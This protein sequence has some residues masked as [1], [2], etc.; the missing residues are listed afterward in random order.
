MSHVGQRIIDDLEN[1]RIKIMYGIDQRADK[2]TY[3]MDIYSP[4][5]ELPVVDAIVVT[6]Y[7]FDEIVE[8]LEGKVNCE[9]LAFDEIIFNL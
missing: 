8:L 4:E 6:A 2:L 7:D 3:D 5:D 9:I 1:S